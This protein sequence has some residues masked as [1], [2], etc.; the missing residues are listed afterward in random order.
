MKNFLELE[1]KTREGVEKFYE[2]IRASEN[3]NDMLEHIN[4]LLNL[5]YRYATQKNNRPNKGLKIFTEY[6][7]IEDTRE[8]KVKKEISKA[9]KKSYKH[10]LKHFQILRNRGYSYKKISDYALKE[11]GIKVTG[12]TINNQLRELEKNV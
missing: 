9:D 3:I 1:A 12:Q 5:S 6:L 11:F 2:D 8:Q 4:L 10:Y 7:K